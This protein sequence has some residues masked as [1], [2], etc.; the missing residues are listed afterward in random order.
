MFQNNARKCK[1]LLSFAQA[2]KY[3]EQ[4][5]KPCGASWRDNE[6]PLY[7][8]PNRNRMHQY[9]LEKLDGGYACTLH[10]TAIVTYFSNKVII[11]VSYNS[12]QTRDFAGCYLPFG[13]LKRYWG[14]S[15]FVWH[16]HRVYYKTYK[17]FVFDYSNLPGE[18][19]KLISE[20]ALCEK[21]VVDKTKSKTLIPLLKKFNQYV[22]GVW[23]LSDTEGIGNHPWVSTHK[24]EEKDESPYWSDE[25]PIIRYLEN[26]EYVKI[27]KRYL[28]CGHSLAFNG[29]IYRRI[30]SSTLKQRVKEAL[31][32]Q[33][34]VWISVP[35]NT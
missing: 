22:D 8:G 27:I 21:V 12:Q 28:P 34:N 24:S 26:E 14:Q 32:K 33:E 11:D 15:A 7:T 13:S 30:L 19:P 17:P 18:E 4:T 9:R 29:Y 16:P 10:N 23:G 5:D 35:Y 6:R 31:Y 3:F 2:E 1:T 25:Y 20:H